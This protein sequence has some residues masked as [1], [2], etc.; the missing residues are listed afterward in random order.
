MKVFAV[1][2]VALIAAIVVGS[3][4]GASSSVKAAQDTG[5]RLAGPVCVGKSGLKN[6]EA[7][8][9]G[10]VRDG[11]ATQR[12]AIL[13][14]G[15]VRSVAK[16]RKCFPWEIRR[17]GV[18]LP[19]IAGPVGPKGAPGERGPQGPPGTGGGSPGPAGPVGPAGQKGDT[20]STGATGAVGAQGPPGPAGAVGAVGPQGQKG[21]TGAAGAGGLGDHIAVLCISNGNNV[22]YGGPTGD[23]CDPGHGDQLLHVVIVGQAP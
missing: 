12:Y 22:K 21:D 17:L 23:L 8:R 4:T 18:G 19:Q 20:G 10:G 5:R 7:S 13:R 9:R 15:V 3:S 16:N 14:A 11:H 1:G 6:L 2:L